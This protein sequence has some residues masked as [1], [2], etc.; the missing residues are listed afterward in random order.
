MASVVSEYDL[1]PHG[2]DNKIK[3]QLFKFRCVENYEVGEK[4]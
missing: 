2:I 1:T 3:L 4:I